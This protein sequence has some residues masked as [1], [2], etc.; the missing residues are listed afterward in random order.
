M[1]IEPIS[2]KCSIVTL[3]KYSF[4]TYIDLFN[5]LVSHKRHPYGVLLSVSHNLLPKPRPYGA[6]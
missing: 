4:V 1:Y 6:F 5:T 2:C 3:N